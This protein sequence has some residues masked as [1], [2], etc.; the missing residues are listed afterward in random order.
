MKKLA[1][2]FSGL[3]LVFGLTTTLSAAEKCGAAKCGAT[4]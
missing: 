1:I 3:F 2:L 4:K